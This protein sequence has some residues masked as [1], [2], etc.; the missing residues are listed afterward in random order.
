MAF[1]YQGGNNP[2]IDY[3][4]LLIA[5]TDSSNPI[6]Q[7]SEILAASQICSFV[8]SV[9]GNG[10]YA[11]SYTPDPRY[12]AATLLESL[13]SN[14]ARL[15]N[16]L[17][18]LDIKIDTKQAA[19]DLRATARVMRDAVDNAPGFMVAE[20]VNDQF[21]ARERWWKVMLRQQQGY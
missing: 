6:F 4:R 8:I 14:A 20:W 9:P 12:V 13:A 21:G 1:T 11:S 15:G 5:D 16:A 19:A 7:D 18:V 10:N 17:T 2:S 3:P